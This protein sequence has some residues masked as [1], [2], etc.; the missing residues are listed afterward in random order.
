[1]PVPAAPAWPARSEGRTAV[2]GERARRR[3]GRPCPATSWR[4]A[5]FLRRRLSP[6]SRR[7]A[8]RGM[9]QPGAASPSLPAPSPSRPPRSHCVHGCPACAREPRVRCLRSRLR[10]IGPC[11]SALPGGAGI[12]HSDSTDRAVHLENR[13]ISSSCVRLDP[14]CSLSAWTTAPVPPARHGRSS[15]GTRLQ[16]P[17]RQFPGREHPDR[18]T[19]HTCPRGAGAGQGQRAHHPDVRPSSRP[20]PEPSCE[21]AW[22]TNALIERLSSSSSGRS[23]RTSA[24]EDTDS[25][26]LTA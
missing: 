16:A 24:T 4:S 26:R 8:L 20:G 10:R 23:A 12:R 15:F 11:R 9:R 1:M 14:P 2:P 18:G 19:R 25:A 13:T 6:A 5:R 7:H 21:R 17:T 22:S 3:P